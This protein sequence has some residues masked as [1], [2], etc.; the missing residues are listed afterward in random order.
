[1]LNF[2][3]SH[4]KKQSGSM[5]TW[6][7]HPLAMKFFKDLVLD[8]YVDATF[9]KPPSRNYWQLPYVDLN[10][11]STGQVITTNDFLASIHFGFLE[12]SRPPTEGKFYFYST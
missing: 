7:D 4:T 8:Q 1:M 6:L 5:D 2:S 3:P 9:E 11:S 10:L 12:Y